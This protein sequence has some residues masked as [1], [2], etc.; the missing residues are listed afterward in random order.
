V[1][2]PAP[3]RRSAPQRAGG[4]LKRAETGL[5]GEPNRVITRCVT[6]CRHRL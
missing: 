1:R 5:G 6:R 2:P 3:G 4:R